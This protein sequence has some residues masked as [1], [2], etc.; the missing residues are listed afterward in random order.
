MVFLG[1]GGG[2]GGGGEVGVANAILC[3]YLRK[4]DLNYKSNVYAKVYL[5][6]TYHL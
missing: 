1:E 3:P 6:T 4:L 2:G 5:D